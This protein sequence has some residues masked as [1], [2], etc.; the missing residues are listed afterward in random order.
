[1]WNRFTVSARQVIVTAQTQR[2]ALRHDFIGTEHLLLGLL[3]D[4]AGPV[5]A[6]LRDAGID[7]D[8]VRTEI[9]AM[10]RRELGETDAE[11]LR[12]IG[13]DLDAVRASVEQT[14]GEGALEAPLP[15]GR[16]RLFGG[17]L[18]RTRLSPRAQK[19]LELSLRESLRLRHD[20]IGPEHILLG[21]LREGE[22]L[23]ASILTRAGLDLDDLRRRT[24]HA[25]GAAA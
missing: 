23:A 22:G 2:R 10:E 21:L 6:L 25:L 7:A 19:V 4:E 15:P 3:D 20:Q 16:R 5:A 9:A 14:F 17:R 1:M 18:P 12:S 8:R 11:A 24:V 13:I